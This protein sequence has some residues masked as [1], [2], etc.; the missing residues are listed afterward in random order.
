MTLY[1]VYRVTRVI[2]KKNYNLKQATESSSTYQ[3]LTA[4]GGFKFAFK[5]NKGD[6]SIPPE[7]GSI[8]LFAWEWWYDAYGYYQENFAEIES[9]DCSEYEL[10]RSNQGQGAK[11]YTPKHGNS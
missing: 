3:E 5:L 6:G 10:G 2:E 9:H 11:L 1:A 4:D 7:V 8:S